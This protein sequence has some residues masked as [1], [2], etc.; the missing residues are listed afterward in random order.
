MGRIDYPKTSIKTYH[1]TLRN[2]PEETQKSADLNYFAAEGW[3]HACADIYEQTSKATSLV[4]SEAPF[5]MYTAEFRF[6]WTNKD[7]T[8]GPGAGH[9]KFSTSFI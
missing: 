8:I 6:P 7:L 1:H 5:I 2:N 4:R 9:L 3:N